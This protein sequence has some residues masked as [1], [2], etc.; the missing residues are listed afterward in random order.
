QV[1][2]VDVM[3]PGHVEMAVKKA[4]VVINAVGPYWRWGTPVIGACVKHGTHYVNLTGEPQWVRRIID[5]YDFGATR[6]H[7]AIV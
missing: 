2:L 3:N 6:T 7:A 4:R 1:L 5:A